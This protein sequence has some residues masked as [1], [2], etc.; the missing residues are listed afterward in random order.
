MQIDKMI[1]MHGLIELAQQAGALGEDDHDVTLNE[2]SSM[3]IC[4]CI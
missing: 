1:Q 3:S 2:N 4:L